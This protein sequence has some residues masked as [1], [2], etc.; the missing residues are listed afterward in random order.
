M[1]L[2]KKF[3]AI[4]IS[5]G[6]VLSASTAFA[7]WTSSGSG[8]GSASADSGAGPGGTTVGVAQTG[9][10]SGLIPGGSAPIA[11]TLTNPSATDYQRVGGV[12]I[13]LPT[14]GWNS[15]CSAA[16]FTVTQPGSGQFPHDLAPSAVFSPTGASL[17]MVAGSGNQDG[18][19]NQTIALSIVAS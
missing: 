7:Y 14:T 9:S 4:A 1:R 11:F 15:G 17:A 6:V 13:S 2:S 5:A 19:K 16:D 8:S 18:C 10:I 12:T 3:A